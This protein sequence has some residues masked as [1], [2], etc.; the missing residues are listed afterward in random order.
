[1]KKLV[2]LCVALLVAPAMADVEFAGACDDGTPCIVT[3]SYTSEPA[4][5]PRGIALKLTCTGTVQ[6][7]DYVAASADPAYNCFIDY[8]FTAGDTYEID[9]TNQHPLAD[10]LAAGVGTV[11]AT[12]ISVCM[13]VLDQEENQAPGPAESTQL[14]QLEVSGTGTIE[15]TADTLR[16]PGSG[17]VGSEIASNLSDGA[18]VV[19]NV[20]CGEEP[21]CMPTCHPDY[22][23]WLD[24]GSPD[25]WCYVRQCYGDTDD[26]ESNYGPEPPPIVPWPKAWVTAEDLAVLVEGYKAVYGGDPEVDTWIAADFNHMENNYGPEPPPIVPWPAARVTA[27]DLSI[28]VANYKAATVPAD[29]LD[30]P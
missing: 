5:A 24:V 28:L 8:A 20:V 18:V 3:I 22:D 4:E 17:V 27:E 25:S 14:L 6:I 1:M 19:I 10:P 16:G 21:P 15:M 23:E 26:I 11:P 13:G 9:P 29:C 2:F 12:E 30:C 7:E